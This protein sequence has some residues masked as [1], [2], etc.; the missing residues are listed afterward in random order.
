[1]FDTIEYMVAALKQ[2]NQLKLFVSRDGDVFNAAEF[3]DSF[4]IPELG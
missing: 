4:K 2:E 1:V 3:P